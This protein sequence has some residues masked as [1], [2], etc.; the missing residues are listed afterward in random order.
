MLTVGRTKTRGMQARGAE[1]FLLE[2]ATFCTGGFALQ[3]ANCSNYDSR[4]LRSEVIQPL[5]PIQEVAWQSVSGS[6]GSVA[7]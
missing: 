3:T 1:F 4:I 5:F 6:A 2:P 7:R